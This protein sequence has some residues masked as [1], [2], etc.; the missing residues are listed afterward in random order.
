MY[1]IFSII[2]AAVIHS[3]HSYTAVTLLTNS[4]RGIDVT[5]R[6]RRAIFYVHKVHDEVSVAWIWWAALWERSWRLGKYIRRVDTNRNLRAFCRNRNQIHTS[7]NMF[8][9]FGGGMYLI[10]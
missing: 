4:R 7:S 2:P 9:G 8:G 6:M 1:F 3:A 5:S 10:L